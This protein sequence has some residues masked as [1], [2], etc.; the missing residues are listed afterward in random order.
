LTK[1]NLSIVVPD[2]LGKAWGTGFYENIR[3]EHPGA[4]IIIVLNGFENRSESKEIYD[5]MNAEGYLPVISEEKGLR[6]ALVYGYQFA[7]DLKGIEYVIRLDTAEHPISAIKR[8][9]EELEAGADMVIG[10]LDLTGLMPEGSVEETFNN[11]VFPR[12]YQA[13]CGVA[14]SCAHGFQGFRHSALRI[15]LDA[16][17]TSN[18]FPE[19]EAGWGFDGLAL[20]AAR[21]HDLSVQLIKVRG[22]VE[23]NRPAGKIVAQYEAALALCK[24]ATDMWPALS[25]KR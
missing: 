6:A 23:R 5:R 25:R 22:E 20:L 7:H 12:L 10:D 14:I 15:I 13:T 4:M 9:L 1:H 3:K 11:L 17:S 8:L 19:Q 24:I 21:A 16:T 2:Y 18:G